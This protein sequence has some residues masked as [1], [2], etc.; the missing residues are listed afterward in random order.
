MPPQN[1]YNYLE[2]RKST[3][4]PNIALCEQGHKYVLYDE[5]NERIKCRSLIK[6]ENENYENY[7]FSLNEKV[8]E[9]NNTYQISYIK[10]TTSPLKVKIIK[11]V[12]LMFVF[13]LLL[14]NILNCCQRS[15]FD[16]EI[17]QEQYE[18]ILREHK[19]KHENN[20]INSRKIDKLRTL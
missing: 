16:Y 17:L 19:H 11:I 2:Y 15:K 3:N 4:F 5:I 8:N 13:I 12:N 7:D 14:L 9:F 18:I 6:E 10:V 20:L 1:I